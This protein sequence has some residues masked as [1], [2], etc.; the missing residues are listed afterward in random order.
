MKTQFK[1]TDTIANILATFGK[2]KTNGTKPFTLVFS[3]V[4]SSLAT[5][6]VSTVANKEEKEQALF[7]LSDEERG[8]LARLQ[9]RVKKEEKRLAMLRTAGKTAERWTTVG[10]VE[11]A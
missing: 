10:E 8:T 3:N 11:L 4:E 7:V 1:G 5:V 6:A 2:V 9:E